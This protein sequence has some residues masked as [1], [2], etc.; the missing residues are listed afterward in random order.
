MT[1]KSGKLTPIARA[2]IKTSSGPGSGAGTSSTSICSGAPNS[3]TIIARTL[4]HLLLESLVR[5]PKDRIAEP[6]LGPPKLRHNRNWQGRYAATI[7]FTLDHP[8]KEAPRVEMLV[9]HSLADAAHHATTHV[10]ALETLLPMACGVKGYPFGHGGDRRFG[11]LGVVTQLVFQ[12]QQIAEVL[13]E[14]L[15]QGRGGDVAPVGCPVDVVAR[16]TAGNQF[17]PWLRPVA[18]DHSVAQRPIEE[19]EDVI[20]HR[21]VEMS[22]IPRPLSLEQPQQ[23]VHD[24]GVCPAADIREQRL[25]YRRRAVGAGGEPEQACFRHV[26]KV[27]SRHPGAGTL[28]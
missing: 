27:M 7:G 18:G 23:D 28:L 13:P 2:S 21:D 6:A 4:T 1:I 15:L 12:L 20:A 19:R 3:L 22:A 24:R 10:V 16:G 11:I 25:R 5:F 26:V 14:T 9:L 17:G 8:V